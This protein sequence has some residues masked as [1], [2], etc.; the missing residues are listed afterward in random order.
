MEAQ[1]QRSL[2]SLIRPAI[3]ISLWLCLLTGFIYPMLTTGVANLLFPYQAQGSLITANGK[4]IGSELIGQNFTRPE[5]FHPRPSA[6]NGT[7][8]NGKTVPQ[9]YTAANSS[10]SNLGPTNQTFIKGV[11]DAVAAYRKENGLA[12]NTPIP[13]D[14]VTASGSGLDPDISIANAS[15]QA[16]RVAQTRRLPVQQVQDLIRKNTSGRQL[17]ILGEDRVNVLKLNLA[18]DAFKPVGK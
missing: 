17:G 18:L 11:Q 8:K 2:F 1:T 10:G 9:P 7:D 3:L 4:V 6:T 14:A 13:V 5:Y 15:L 12:A 16:T